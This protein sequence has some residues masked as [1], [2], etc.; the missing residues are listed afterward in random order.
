MKKCVLMVCVITILIGV[1][2]R[3]HACTS[4]DIDITG[5]WLLY[6]GGNV[7]PDVLQF[8]SDGTGITATLL[9]YV[10]YD[11]K[12]I[13][14]NMLQ[15]YQKVNWRLT[16]DDSHNM[17]LSIA[18]AEEVNE[19]QLL[20]EYN[21]YPNHPFLL[22]LRIWDAGGGWIPVKAD[23]LSYYLNDGAQE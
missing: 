8:Y 15:N 16:T 7:A 10:C 14:S 23:D 9:D 1:S 3:S 12:Y 5:T 2:S 21:V 19:Y 4:K 11:E 20:F 13:S 18:G 17:V 22:C 6:S